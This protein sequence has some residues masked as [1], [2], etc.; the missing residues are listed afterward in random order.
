MEKNILLRAIGPEFEVY[1]FLN[2]IDEFMEFYN[3]NIDNFDIFEIANLQD[4]E[5]TEINKNYSLYD[6]TLAQTNEHF[7]LVKDLASGVY[8]PVDDKQQAEE[9]ISRLGGTDE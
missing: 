4:V 6:M 8:E 5:I 2:N 7:W 3:A 9:V 1:Q